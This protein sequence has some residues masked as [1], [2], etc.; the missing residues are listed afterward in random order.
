MEEYENRPTALRRSTLGSKHPDLELAELIVLHIANLERYGT[1]SDG[2]VLTGGGIPRYLVNRG[3][4]KGGVV[5]MLNV[6]GQ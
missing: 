2:R 1:P 4:P 3:A 6:F 5:M